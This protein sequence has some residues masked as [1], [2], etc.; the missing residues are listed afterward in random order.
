MQTNCYRSVLGSR[1]IR[2]S[3]L[4]GVFAIITL[5]Y[6]YESLGAAPPDLCVIP[7]KNSTFTVINTNNI[8]FGSLRQA[9]LDANA[10]PGLDDINF[11]IPGAG[12][13]TINLLSP[14]SYC[15]I[16]RQGHPNGR[17]LTLRYP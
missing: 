14:L 16:L 10:S 8:G 2:Y 6:L 9:I 12:P 13:H 11:D 1:R 3:I 4:A 15:R 5:V 7:G 17:C